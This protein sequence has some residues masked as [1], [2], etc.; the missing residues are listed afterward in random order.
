[1]NPRI[2]SIGEAATIIPGPSLINF[3]RKRDIA[4]QE[5]QKGEPSSKI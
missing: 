2:Y 4:I 5:D 1:L 3:E